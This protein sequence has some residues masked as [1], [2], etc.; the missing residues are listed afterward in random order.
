MLPA[1][2][3]SVSDEAQPSAQLTRTIPLP[4]EESS[5]LLHTSRPQNVGVSHTTANHDPGVTSESVQT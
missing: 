2:S 4:P 5:T 3:S 1:S